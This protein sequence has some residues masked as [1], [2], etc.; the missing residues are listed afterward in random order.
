MNPRMR[1][2]L[3]L[4]YMEPA[5]L[6]IAANAEVRAKAPAPPAIE[7]DKSLA[8]MRMHDEILPR[9]DGWGGATFLDDFA[10]AYRSLLADS[11][12]GGILI[13]ID[14]PGGAVDGT[15]EMADLLYS[16]RGVKPVVAIANTMAASAAFWLGTSAEKF[17]ATRSA[18]VGSVGVV[19][20]HSDVTKAAERL[21]FTFT[22][23]TAGQFKAEFS[24]FRVLSDEARAELQARVD[25]AYGWF[26]DGLARNRGTSRANVEKSYGQGRVMSAKAALAAG[27]IDGIATR[28]EVIAG[29]LRK[30]HPGRS[31]STARARAKINLEAALDGA[32]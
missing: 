13:D 4:W 26:V 29:M 8:V 5:A 22:T 7:R 10:S 2:G 11:S 24:P 30:A 9:N 23:V 6:E 20:M 31:T 14:S 18:S 3:S 19:A 28:D 1:S 17:Y 16:T 12:V 25:E 32:G 21:G 27:M 15:P